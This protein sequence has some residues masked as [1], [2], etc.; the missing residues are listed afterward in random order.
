MKFKSDIEQYLQ[1]LR[2]QSDPLR[3]S[4]RSSLR[5]SKMFALSRL[6]KLF[7]SNFIQDRDLVMSEDEYGDNG[8]GED[9]H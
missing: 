8:Q 1:F 7:S 9:K 4:R 5:F 2:I 3:A 6:H